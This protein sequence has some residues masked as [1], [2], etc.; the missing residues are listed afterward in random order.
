MI[1]IPTPWWFSLFVLCMFVDEG[2]ET[3][4]CKSV[5]HLGYWVN[6]ICSEPFGAKSG[7]GHSG[8]STKRVYLVCKCWN[9]LQPNSGRCWMGNK[10][11]CVVCWQKHDRDA[12]SRLCDVLTEHDA[13]LQHK[14]WVLLASRSD[15]S[16]SPSR[17][18]LANL[19]CVVAFMH[20]D[21]LDTNNALCRLRSR[22]V[23]FYSQSTA[24]DKFCTFVGIED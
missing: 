21:V 14:S 24:K 15:W 12:G 3:S 13:H 9:L 8:G 7:P 20:K 4:V 18:K 22:R 2:L 1:T 5:H 11:D 16:V 19:L 23:A 6:M 10:A 17:H